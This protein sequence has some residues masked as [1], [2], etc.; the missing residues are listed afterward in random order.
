LAIDLTSARRA[1]LTISSR[2]LA[3]ADTVLG[4]NEKGGN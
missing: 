1:H 4:K 3:V 2:L